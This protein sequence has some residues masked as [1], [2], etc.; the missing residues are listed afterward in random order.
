LPI[1]YQ[2]HAVSEHESPSELVVTTAAIGK[3]NQ[4]LCVIAADGFHA[5]QLNVKLHF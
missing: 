2:R 5:I 3:H 1:V 4:C